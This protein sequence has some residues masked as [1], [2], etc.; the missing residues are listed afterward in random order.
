[1]QELHGP[2][3]TR[4]LLESAHKVS[5]A[6]GPRVKQGLFKNLGQTYLQVLE[7]LKGRQGSAV[8]HYGGR[9]MEVEE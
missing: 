6:L 3:G 2:G 9:T 8:S 1:M 5:C 4:P 7:G